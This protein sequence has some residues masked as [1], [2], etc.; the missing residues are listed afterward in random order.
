MS[1]TML[2][3]T[4]SE[5]VSLSVKCYTSCRMTSKMSM[6]GVQKECTLDESLFWGSFA[7]IRS[8]ISVDLGCFFFEPKH[9]F[10]NVPLITI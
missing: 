5:M 1:K 9:S 6:G 4:M 8:S 3:S 7:V 2:M 10:P